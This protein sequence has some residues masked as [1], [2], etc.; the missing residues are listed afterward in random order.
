MTYDKEKGY[1][2][3]WYIGAYDNGNY[4]YY[5]LYSVSKESQPIF[6]RDH[7]KYTKDTPDFPEE[8][9]PTP[10]P[11][12]PV[13]TSTEEKEEPVVE[14][15][16]EEQPSTI[17]EPVVE[18]AKPVEEAKEEPEKVEETVV[19]EAPVESPAE[20]KTEETNKVKEAK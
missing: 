14:E 1:G 20:D 12:K 19:E 9:N 13:E 16:V 18:E 10:E 8:E 4:T 6:E 11:E 15:K 5:S 2:Q 7:K 3:D 17:A